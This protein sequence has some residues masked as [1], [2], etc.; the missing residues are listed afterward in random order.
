MGSYC[1]Y[2]C[3]LCGYSV[4][5]HTG[6]GLSYPI[7]RDELKKEILA[8][9][10]DK[11]KEVR[12]AMKRFPDAEF[13]CS[14]SVYVCDKCESLFCVQSIELRGPHEEREGFFD[15]RPTVWRLVPKCPCCSSD[16]RKTIFCPQCKKSP[17]R[18]REMGLWD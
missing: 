14:N 2:Y 7:I 11:W 10:T 6:I 16:L 8:D 15:S 18:I 3:P 5:F 12:E 4:P 9:A 17:L 13:A 1:L